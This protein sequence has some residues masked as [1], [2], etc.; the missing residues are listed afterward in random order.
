ME[1]CQY[2]GESDD[3]S[4][5]DNENYGHFIPVSEVILQN[6][7][8]KQLYKSYGCDVIE[9]NGENDVSNL[10]AHLTPINEG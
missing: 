8:R 5:N 1:E 7:K 3:E 6:E 4:D 2:Y 9:G 10:T